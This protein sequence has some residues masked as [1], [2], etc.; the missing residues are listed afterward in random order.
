MTEEK[1]CKVGMHSLIATNEL[2]RESES[3]HQTTLLQ[4]KYGS[5]GAGEEDTLNGREGNETFSE[6]GATIGDPFEGPVSFFLNAR[7][8]LNRIKEVFTLNRVLNVR[9]NE[10]RIG[11]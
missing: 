8:S 2:V 10:K 1:A 7:D 4:P 5:K 3:R 11:F 9:V 6:C